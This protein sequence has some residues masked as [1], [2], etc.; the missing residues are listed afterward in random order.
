MGFRPYLVDRPVFPIRESIANK[1]CIFN[2]VSA[3]HLF[4]DAYRQ[5]IQKLFVFNFVLDKSLC[6][7]NLRPN[8]DFQF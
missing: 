3:N 1:S 4:S 6:F 8:A 7:C 2:F 5:K